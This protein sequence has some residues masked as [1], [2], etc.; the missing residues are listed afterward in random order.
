M[1]GVVPG[2]GPSWPGTADVTAS[3]RRV[4]RL[5]HGRTLEVSSCG[6]MGGAG[7]AGLPVLVV[8]GRPGVGRHTLMRRI[9]GV[10]ASPLPSITETEDPGVWRIETKYFTVDVRV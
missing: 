9:P 3:T 7:G 5:P 6:V 8:A 1:D 10:H 4:Q 2:F